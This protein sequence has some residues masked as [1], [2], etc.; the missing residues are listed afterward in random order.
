[1]QQNA[2][3]QGGDIDGTVI[4]MLTEHRRGEVWSELAAA[5]RE[6]AGAVQLVGKSGTVTLKIKLAVAQGTSNTLV[7]SDDISKNIP[8][9]SKQGT[10]FYADENNNLVRNDPNQHD[11]PLQIV[12]PQRMARPV[13]PVVDI[14]AKSTP[15]RE[16]VAAVDLGGK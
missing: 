8:K 7:I 16:P 5:L 3:K 11:L 15:A 10:I 12:D 6:V 14:S 9:A 13:V 2:G 1:M 4:S